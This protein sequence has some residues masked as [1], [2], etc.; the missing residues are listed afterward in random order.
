MN[1]AKT[2]G[3]KPVLPDKVSLE[4]I[5]AQCD[6]LDLLVFPN[7]T[8]TTSFRGN[9]VIESDGQVMKVPYEFTL[10]GEDAVKSYFAAGKTHNAAKL[11]G[12]LANAVILNYLTWKNNKNQEDDDL[13]NDQFIREI[14]VASELYLIL[15]HNHQ[16]DGYIRNAAL[17]FNNIFHILNPKRDIDVIKK[18][19]EYLDET[20]LPNSKDNKYLKQ[21]LVR[22]YV[23]VLKQ[24][25]KAAR[26]AGEDPELK[27]YLP[28]KPAGAKGR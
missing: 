11:I 15:H 25:D 27:R 8:V 20:M 12:Y 2:D 13:Y 7:F 22:A 28:E 14:K 16:H 17:L 4:N 10:T 19:A 5:L 26:L 3:K 21:V 6:F 9:I 18:L 24:Y 23:D 1:D